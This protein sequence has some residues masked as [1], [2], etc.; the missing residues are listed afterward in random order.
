M[1]DIRVSQKIWRSGSVP[2]SRQKVEAG[3]GED[4]DERA[5]SSSVGKRCVK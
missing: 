5:V 1:T 3:G 4:I 2:K